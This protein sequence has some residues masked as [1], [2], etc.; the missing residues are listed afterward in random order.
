MK[1]VHSLWRLS[2]FL[3][4]ALATAKADPIEV[5]QVLGFTPGIRGA[6]ELTFPSE[7]GKF[8]QVQISADMAT[9]DN[10]GYSVKGTGG[11]V[12]ILARTR[13]LPN[14]YY[15]LRDDGSPD[16]VAPTGPAGSDA[17]VTAEAI[18]EA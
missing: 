9:W 1:T 18:A 17:T 10:E 8:Y 5:G 6:V 7:V 13:N 2:L 15:R 11:Q 14:A 3:F 4:V 12:S 16:N